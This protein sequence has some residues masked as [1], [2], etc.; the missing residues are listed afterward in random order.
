MNDKE[1]IKDLKEGDKVV[2]SSRHGKSITVVTKITPKGFV[3]TDKYQFNQ[4]GSQRGNSD[5]WNP[6]YLEQLT[7]EVLLEFKKNGL[8]RKCKEIKFSELSIEQIEQILSI[9]DKL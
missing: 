3:K 4:D 9:C 2:V 6:F 1:W 5:R 8:V 7:D